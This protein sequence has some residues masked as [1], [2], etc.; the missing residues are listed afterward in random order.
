MSQVLTLERTRPGIEEHCLA[1]APAVPQGNEE[2][3]HMEKTSAGS[4]KAFLSH[5]HQDKSFVTQLGTELRK[6]GVDA[7]LDQW[8]IKPGDSL[9]RKIFYEGLADCRLFVVVL[10]KAS[11]QSPWVREELDHATIQRLE[12]ATRVVPVLKEDCEIPAPLRTLLWIDM[13]TDFEGGVRKLVNLA[14][15]VSDKPPLGNRPPHVL[16]SVNS[17]GGLSKLASRVGLWL[18]SEADH[19]HGFE[20]SYSGDQLASALS[21]TATELNDAVGELESLGLVRTLNYL[22]TAPYEFGQLEPT[23]ALFIHF[24][25][26]LPA[27]YDP[28]SDAKMVAA[29]VAARSQLSGAELQTITGVPITRLNRAVQYLQDYGRIQVL[30]YTGTAPY[31][32]GTVLATRQTRQLADALR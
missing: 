32:F 6:S 25:D 11:V 20:K 21:L 15:G 13:R 24:R 23:Y 18:V 19:E 8:E 26:H 30:R 3:L 28:D 7:W 12:G 22:G 31:D 1:W 14:F 9:I 4:P 5:S 29:A 2:G 27:G 10:S 16:E 17:V